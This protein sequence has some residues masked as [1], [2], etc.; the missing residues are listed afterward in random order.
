LFTAPVTRL[1]SA[2]TVTTSFTWR[3]RLPS[4]VL[5]VPVVPELQRSW[6]DALLWR[7]PPNLPMR[8]LYQVYLTCRG[9]R[10][11][12]VDVGANDGS[13][14]WLFSLAGWRCVAFEPQPDCVTFLRRVAAM[15]RF[16]DLA[17]EQSAVGD[18]PTSTATLYVSASSWF[19]SLDRAHV[20][21][22]EPPEPATVKV[23]TLDAY[24]Q[25]HALRPTCIK[26]DVEGHE[27]HVLRGARNVIAEAK[28]DLIVEVSRNQ[29]I[30]EGIWQLLA[31]LDYCAYALVE[32]GLLPISMLEAFHMVTP[33]AAHIDALFTV[34][35]ELGQQLAASLNHR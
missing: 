28:P 15:N 11:T 9:P 23:V 21:R 16:T 8:R 18:Q 19:S 5:M 24:C 27:L 32:S 29:N 10:G 14:S 22:F 2:A 25:E 34:D 33:E 3:A 1:L 4:G 7:W 17:V 6:T 31:P 30:R 35:R 12:L 26:I 20:Q 13:H